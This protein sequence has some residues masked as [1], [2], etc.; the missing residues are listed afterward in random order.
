MRLNDKQTTY[1]PQGLGRQMFTSTL[2]IC[3]IIAARAI[4]YDFIN[5]IRIYIIR[6]IIIR[7]MFNSVLP[8][9]IHVYSIYIYEIIYSRNTEYVIIITTV[10]S[11]FPP[12]PFSLSDYSEIFQCSYFFLCLDDLTLQMLD[13][14][15]YFHTI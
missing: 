13:Y 14:I 6:V 3:K 12:L 5:T 9:L 1:L 10:Y 8:I 4:I 2:V 7:N 11:L 15:L